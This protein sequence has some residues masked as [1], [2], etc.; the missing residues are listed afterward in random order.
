MEQ[1]PNN[2]R[3]FIFAGIG[4]ALGLTALKFF[5]ST[6]KKEKQT[7]K[8]L[9]QEGKLVVEA[10]VEPANACAGGF[11]VPILWPLGYSTKQNG[12]KGASRK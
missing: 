3:K 9:S 4:T 7:V 12:Q 10:G 8:M 1:K 11:T 6:P 5:K 2:R